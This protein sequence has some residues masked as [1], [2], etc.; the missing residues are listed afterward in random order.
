MGAGFVSMSGTQTGRDTS[1]DDTSEDDTSE[2]DT[3]KKC[4]GE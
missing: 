3:G 4:N 2:Y 1:E